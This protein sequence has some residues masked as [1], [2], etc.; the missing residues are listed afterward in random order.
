MPKERIKPSSA[1]VK[2]DVL[3]I[4]PTQGTKQDTKHTVTPAG[5]KDSS[6][7]PLEESYIALSVEVSF[8]LLLFPFETTNRRRRW[9]TKVVRPR[10]G[11]CYQ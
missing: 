4:S 2:A 5:V 9:N 1:A 10:G 8:V 6:A 3:T 11:H 7:N